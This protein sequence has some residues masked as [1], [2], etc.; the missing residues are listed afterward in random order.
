MPDYTPLS[1]L[2]SEEV[3]QN[4]GNYSVVASNLL[5]ISA[6]T[7]ERRVAIPH[8]IDPFL[9]F[10]YPFGK[11][12]LGAIYF[13]GLHWHVLSLFFEGRLVKVCIWV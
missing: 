2:T 10:L 12:Q 1:G 13:L 11:L 3:S 6:R 9:C 4:L 7:T 5:L 8:R